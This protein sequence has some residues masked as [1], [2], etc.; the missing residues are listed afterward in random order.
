MGEPD[1]ERDD[2]QQ[3]RGGV[4]GQGE[5]DRA[6]GAEGVAGPQEGQEEEGVLHVGGEK[7]GGIFYF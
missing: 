4:D 5:E 6:G 7:G 2:V 3:E 1:R